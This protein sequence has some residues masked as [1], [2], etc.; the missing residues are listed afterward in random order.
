MTPR[1]I[2]SIIASAWILAAVP[3]A[4]MLFYS[5]D[6]Y[7][8]S[9]QCGTCLADDDAVTE[10]FLILILPGSMSCFVALLLNVYVATRVYYSHRNIENETQ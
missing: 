9:A 3:F 8:N 2:V 7:I 1:V 4:S 10:V 6:G 5:V